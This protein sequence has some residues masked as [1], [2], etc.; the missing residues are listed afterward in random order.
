MIKEIDLRNFDSSERFGLN[1][2]KSFKKESRKAIGNYNISIKNMDAF[3]G[4][5]SDIIVESAPKP[6]NDY[7]T[8]S[9]D[10]LN[11]IS[12]TFGFDESNEQQPEFDA[13]PHVQKTSSNATAVHINQNHKAIPIFQAS[14]TVKFTPNDKIN[15]SVGNIYTITK[16]T[17]LFYYN[18][19]IRCGHEGY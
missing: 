7:V 6:S 4:N 9:L 13:D 18:F 2:I 19:F 11:N 15:G 5:P 8:R 10:Y 14:T 16:E 3:S 12:S 17:K 1:E